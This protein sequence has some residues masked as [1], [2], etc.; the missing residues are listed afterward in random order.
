LKNIIMNEIPFV[1]DEQLLLKSL[2][3]KNTYDIQAISQLCSAAKGVA[4]P[5]FIYKVSFIEKRGD[6][7]VVLDG[8]R[9]QSRVMSINF[10]SLNRVFP[11]MATSGIEIEEW[12]RGIKGML[13]HY[14]A[15]KIKEMALE[16]ARC[17]GIEDVCDR[18][19]LKKISSMSPGSIEDWPLS[20]QVELFSLLGN[21]VPEIGVELTDSLLMLPPK[22]IS[23]IIFETDTDYQNCQLCP[24]RNCA[25]R[26]AAYIPRLYEKKYEL[27][28]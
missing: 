1:P 25:S 16:Q 14:W 12:S 3:V 4:R 2:C 6:D 11:F 9:F 24:R 23:L 28:Q 22:S 10:A 17:K 21:A 13:H 15:D 20:E 7:F 18:F 8:V 19:K 26:R 5:K 27:Q